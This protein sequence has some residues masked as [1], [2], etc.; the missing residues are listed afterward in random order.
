MILKRSP[1]L[2]AR[3]KL[4]VRGPRALAAGVLLASLALPGVASAAVVE[5][6]VAVV[7]EQAI[8]LSELRTR[9]R[10]VLQR[11]YQSTPAGAQRAAASSQV[12]KEVLERMVDDELQ[13]RAANQARITVSAQEI[14][15]AMARVA[16]QNR[17]TVEKL[18]SE[19]TGSGL[20]L[21]D[22]RAE[23]R[24]QLLEAKLLNL[25]IS[26]R[27]RVTEPDLHSS[28]RKIVLEERRKLSFRVAWI[29]IPAG[30]HESAERQQQQQ[31]ARRVAAEAK[32]G[33]FAQLAARHSADAATRAQGGLLPP[34]LPSA[35]PRELARAVVEL[36][37]GQVTEPIRVADAFVIVKLVEREGSELPTF[38][39][40]KEQLYNRVY[41]EKMGKARD[42][43]LRNLRS[44]T[45]VE[46][47]L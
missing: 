42:Q 1:K 41:M 10:P 45:H 8:L 18:I 44:R 4:A 19:A 7:G 28:Y 2:P 9:A 6:V 33:D 35:L 37:P 16:R 3:A 24:R 23:L 5:R 43:W 14:D 32:A 13:R 34:Q 26:G 21:A 36:E 11:V 40:A 20:T 30:E 15:D 39:E 17:I 46:V 29:H 31:L 27:I 25:R 12:Y 38:D 22:Y 47:R